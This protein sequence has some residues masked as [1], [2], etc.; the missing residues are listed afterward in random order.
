VRPAQP[1]SRGAKRGFVDMFDAITH[2]TWATTTFSFQ[3]ASGEPVAIDYVEQM[4]GVC[5]AARSVFHDESTLSPSLVAGIVGDARRAESRDTPMG[6]G[7]PGH[8]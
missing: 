6:T 5:W 7:E 8:P 1:P 2:P 3:A 4:I